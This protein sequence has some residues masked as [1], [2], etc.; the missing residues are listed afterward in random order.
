MIAP[1]AGDCRVGPDRREGRAPQCGLETLGFC[2]EALST[3]RPQPESG[4]GQFLPQEIPKAAPWTGAL[5]SLRPRQCLWGDEGFLGLEQT[6][7]GSRL[8][9]SEFNSKP[10][11]P[12]SSESS[13]EPRP[14][15]KGLRGQPTGPVLTC[16]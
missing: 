2:P 1:K 15:D 4:A 14:R 10:S 11:R 3:L 13:L 6:S 9:L 5:C 7:L 8:L 16:D 12:F